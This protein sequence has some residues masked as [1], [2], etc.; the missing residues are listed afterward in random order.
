[1]E[2]GTDVDVKAAKQE[3]KDA[4]DKARA[5]LPQD[6]TEEPEVIEIDVSQLP[7][8]N[9]NVSGNM[10]LH[11]L[12]EYADDLQDKI[13]G[14]SEISRVDM[15]GAPEREI[16]INVDKARMEAAGITMFDIFNAVQSE[17]VSGSAGLL[18]MDGIKRTLTVAG[19]F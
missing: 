12:K 8:M 11:V 14:L 2:F 5:E 13:E 6:L 16:Q 18:K 9:V 15:G 10:E 17:N 3:V 7:I 4:V 19:E 1:V